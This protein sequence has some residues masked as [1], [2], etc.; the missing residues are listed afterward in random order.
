MDER[1]EEGGE[2]ANRLK[3]AMEAKLAAEPAVKGT[4][5]CPGCAS[6][7]DWYREWVECG[8]LLARR[9]CDAGD[10]HNKSDA[11]YCE[12]P[13][14]FA[15]FEHAAVCAALGVSTC[16]HSQR[17]QRGQYLCANQLFD[18]TLRPRKVRLETG[19]YLSY[20][21]RGGSRRVRFARPP[22]KLDSGP[23]AWPSAHMSCREHRVCCESR[24]AGP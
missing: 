22:L 4:I 8:C 9:L 23:R 14:G 16:A 18:E 24:S 12:A 17:L 15:M 3:A 10:D 1:E 11:Q 2:R 6:D 5:A 19:G 7:G 13:R 20:R 21:R